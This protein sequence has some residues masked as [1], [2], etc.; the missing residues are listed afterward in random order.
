MTRGL[1]SFFVRLALSAAVLWGAVAFVTP[2]NP[3]NTLGT[4]VLISVVLSVAY[5]VT[6]A[7][8]LWFLVLPWLLYAAFWL[9]TVMAAYGLGLLQAG[10]VALGMTVLSWV[11]E[12]VF[13]V[14]TFRKE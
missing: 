1:L 13:G 7:R 14:K 3:A 5:Y 4:A 12:K 2:G 10:V 9:W 11:V 8:F 6:L